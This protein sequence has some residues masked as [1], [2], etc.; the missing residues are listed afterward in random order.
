MPTLN[1]SNCHMKSVFLT[2][3]KKNVPS[4]AQHPHFGL[5]SRQPL[6]TGCLLT[7]HLLSGSLQSPQPTPVIQ[8]T[9]LGLCI[10][11]FIST[12]PFPTTFPLHGALTKE[13]QMNVSRNSTYITIFAVLLLKNNQVLVLVPCLRWSYLPVEYWTEN[14]TTWR[15]HWVFETL[16]P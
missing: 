9:S 7:G 6:S 8:V 2:F 10:W 1:I 3:L 14:I 16:F 5:H 12:L 11:D 13:E 4:G 15:R